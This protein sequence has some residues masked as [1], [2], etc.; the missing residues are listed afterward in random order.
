MARALTARGVE[1]AKPGSDRRE[2][3]DGGLPGFY[4]VVQPSG[5]KSWALRYR[6]HGKPRK[7]TL[8]KYPA[9]RLAD[10]REAAREALAAVHRG[11]DPAAVRK[12]ARADPDRDLVRT[13]AAEFLKRHASKNRTAAETE[14]I[15]NREVLPNWGH[16][17]VGRIERRDVI[18]LLDAI[19]DRGA[20]TMANRT[21]A[22]IRK[23]FNWAVER[24]V[25]KESPCAGVKPPAPERKR[26][27][28]LTDDE[29]RAFWRATA[30]L[31]PPFGPLFR[32]MLLTGQRQSEVAEMAEGELRGDVWVIPAGRAKNGKEHCVSLSVPAREALAAMPR[33]RNPKGFVFSTNGQTPP[34]GFSK[35]KA[36]LDCHMAAHLDGTLE[37]FKLHDLRRTAASGMARAGARVEVVER[38]LNHVSGSFAGVAGVYQRHSYTKEVRAA[39]EAWAELIG[40]IIGD[41]PIDAPGKLEQ[42]QNK[43][44]SG[45]A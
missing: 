22:T 26:D 3:P 24:D 25:I 36:R 38:V 21:L 37:P 44:Y 31:G 13:V 19:V 2:I 33:I 28:I 45:S 9:T 29:L 7:L 1:A 12:A 4:L 5:A 32:V 23:L 43:T 11:E 40:R 42:E 17:K 30:E 41:A 14:R 39:L 35:A 10:A 6:A 16:R 15:L 34:S 8:G 18:E 20:P 27:R